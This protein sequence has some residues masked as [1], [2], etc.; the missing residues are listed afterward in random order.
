[1]KNKNIKKIILLIPL[2]FASCKQ[3][4]NE[5]PLHNLLEH[6]FINETIIKPATCLEEGSK[7][8]KCECGAIIEEKIPATGHKY[9]YTVKQE[10]TCDRVGILEGKCACGSVIEKVESAKEHD[11]KWEIKQEATCENKEI[12]EGKCSLCNDVIIKENDALGHSYGEYYFVEEATTL[13]E[14]LVK[15]SCANGCLKDKTLKILK[16]PVINRNNE[17]ISW[18]SVD[19]ATGYKLYNGDTFVEDLGNVLSYKIPLLTKA[20]YSYS[21][22]AYTD[23][24]EYV[25]VSNKSNEIDV[26]ISHGSD[27]QAGLSDFEYYKNDCVYL[28]SYSHES[29]STF[30]DAGSVKILKDSDN[31]YAKLHP[32]KNGG[33]ATLTNAGNV[34]VTKAGTYTVSIDVKLG[35]A[36]DGSLNLVGLYV[37]P[38]ITETQNLQFDLTKANTTSW[39]TLTCE[40]TLAADAKH[41]D[42][43][44]KA[45]D[46][47]WVNIDIGYTANT[48][49]ENNYVL[50][51]NFKISEKGKTANLNSGAN[52]TFESIVFASE[53]LKS[54]NWKG[55][56][57]V[58]PD[59]LENSLEIIENDNTVLKMYASKYK[60]PV[61]TVRGN[62]SIGGAGI[63]KLTL[64]VKA[65]PDA[66][67]L[68]SVGFRMY[69]AEGLLV[70]DVRFPEVDSVNSDG[71]VTLET[72]FK[73]LSSKN[74]SYVNIEVFA[75]TNNDVD[76]S[77]NNYLLIDNLSVYK[78]D[79][80]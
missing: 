12:L 33:N 32:V 76:S 55:M 59:S 77:V 54:Y 60:S 22:E 39:T 28:N 79:I 7:T 19:N 11:Y 52:N 44:N 46:P 4:N 9:E 74:T 80:Q 29:W 72:T 2:L 23:K 30:S 31:K 37:D 78:V 58:M 67:R 47:T 5:K 27:L 70:S 25:E 40:Y 49:G 34:N 24:E 41:I 61:V 63:Y 15:A 48:H 45:S 16:T 21:I 26:L 17:V 38:W 73:V 8:L 75:F 68:G 18:E 65:G 51:D 10:A 20:G 50:V 35:S 1:M 14:G 64:D 6:Q 56:V 36:V 43:K 13:K 42:S 69:Y 66:N 57:Y 53:T 62:P 71:W 3:A